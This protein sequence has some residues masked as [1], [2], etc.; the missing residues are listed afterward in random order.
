MQ[1]EVPYYNTT[2]KHN[3]TINTITKSLQWNS[4]E[5]ILSAYLSILTTHNS[6]FY[7]A[8][9]LTTA[10]VF[11][12]HQWKPVFWGIIM[13][14]KCPEASEL[15]HKVTPSAFNNSSRCLVNILGLFKGVKATYLIKWMLSSQMICLHWKVN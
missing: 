12:S 13:C 14:G 3:N 8:I 4:R 11:N 10:H 15:Y 2:L 6:E 9:Q 5:H 1:W 7:Y